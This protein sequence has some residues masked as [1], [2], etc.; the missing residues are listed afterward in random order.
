[1][2]KGKDGKRWASNQTLTSAHSRS[3]SEALSSSVGVCVTYSLSVIS[4]HLLT[5]G[6]TKPVLISA[7]LPITSIELS[8]EKRT[9]VSPMWETRHRHLF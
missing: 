2:C 4:L 5:N 9:A 6:Y 3:T 7:S 8:G 1:M